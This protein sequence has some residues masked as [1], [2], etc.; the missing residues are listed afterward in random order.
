M[1][2][3]SS[4]KAAGQAFEK[5]AHRKLSRDELMSNDP[6]NDG[7]L[8]R[9]DFFKR[10]AILGAAVTGAGSF[11]AAC[12][13]SGDKG[14]GS[15]QQ[16]QPSTKGGDLSCN[17]TEGLE[18]AQ[19]KVRESLKYTDDSP[20]A[21]KTCDNCKLYT[22]PET[23]GSCGGCTTVPGPIHPKGWCSAWVAAA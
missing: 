2:T 23:A 5:N 6:T 12:E 14:G 18:P 1:S 21:G 20:E 3:Q 8:N 15:Q 10:A 11:L 22:Q 7:K 16:Q 4:R 13:P 19:I 9:R 17:D